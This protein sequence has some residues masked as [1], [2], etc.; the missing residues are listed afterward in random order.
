MGDLQNLQ[1]KYSKLI[2]E[3]EWLIGQDH[4][5]E[6]EELI[7]A[8]RLLATEVERLMGALQEAGLSRPTQYEACKHIVKGNTLH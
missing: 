6:A 3:L 7:I 2:D 5:P 8:L 4:G 1:W